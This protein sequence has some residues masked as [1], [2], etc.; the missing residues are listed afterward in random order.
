[1]TVRLIKTTA[2]GKTEWDKI[3]D[4][5]TTADQ[6]KT[7]GLKWDDTADKTVQITIN[8]AADLKA[9]ET[10]YAVG[11]W[12]QANAWSRT[13]GVKLAKNGGTYT[14][15]AKVDR[16]HAMA[17]RLIKVDASGRSTWDPATD[18]RTTADKTK[19][20]GVTWSNNKVNEDGSIPDGSDVSITGPG[21]EDGK[22][23]LSSGSLVQLSVAGTSS[24][25]DMWWSDGA[26]VAV[27]GAGD[28]YAVRKGTAKVNAKVDGKTVSITITVK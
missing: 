16:N 15:T 24:K 12:G 5:K 2:D 14:G 7:I 21:V 11:D 28:V 26:A 8:A 10:L 3:G 18:R 4:V 19:T 25:V 9:G 23:T 1:M 20:I 27:S 17:F 13:S 22:L 6:S